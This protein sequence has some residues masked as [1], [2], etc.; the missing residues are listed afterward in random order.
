[1]SDPVQETPTMKQVRSVC[2]AYRH[3]YGLLPIEEPNRLAAEAIACWRAIAK[4]INEP[5]NHPML[6][7]EAN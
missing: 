1:M 6:N 2:M 7:V 3:D 4:E 5:S